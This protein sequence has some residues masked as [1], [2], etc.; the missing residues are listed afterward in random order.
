MCYYCHILG[1]NRS[2]PDHRS[3]NCL[4]INNTYSKYYQGY[5]LTKNDVF[6]KYCPECKR[7]TQHIMQANNGYETAAP[8]CLVHT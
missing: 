2:A 5:I 1:K 6:F 7:N 4:N 3:E 8:R